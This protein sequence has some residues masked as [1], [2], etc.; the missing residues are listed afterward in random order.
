MQETYMLYLMHASRFSNDILTLIHELFSYFWENSI[1]NVSL[2]KNNNS[3]MEFFTYYPFDNHLQCKMPVVRKINSY[4]G[5]WSTTIGSVQE[6]SIFPEKIHD[7]NK[8]PL[9]VAV[10]DTPPYLSYIKNDEGVYDID[11]F[12]AKLLH[13]LAE[14]LNFSLD[15]REP[16]NNEQ[17]GKV[18]ANGT[19][20]GAMKMVRFVCRNIFLSMFNGG[21]S[22]F[23]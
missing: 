2:M 21:K 16:P 6:W 13:V 15:L 14:K 22:N 20:T 5:G 18:Q 3:T 23:V 8:C 9:T 4:A 17:R 10:W 1:I 7:L 12:E 19:L 11:Y